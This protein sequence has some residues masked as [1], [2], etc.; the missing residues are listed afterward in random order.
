M[1][2][3]L[4][5]GRSVPRSETRRFR[6]RYSQY[7]QILPNSSFIR[8]SMP[9]R[10]Q[11]ARVISPET[12]RSLS[13]AACILAPNAGPRIRTLTSWLCRKLRQFRLV[14]PTVD[15]TPSMTAVFA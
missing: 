13:N 9:R 11:A 5:T 2:L 12:A 8:T 7:S 1:W 15:H 14:E 6:V 3:W 10:F 4:K